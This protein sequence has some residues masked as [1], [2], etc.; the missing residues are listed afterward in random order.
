MSDASQQPD[1]T[2][3]IAAYNAEDTLARSIDSALAQTSVAVEVVVV[4]DCSTDS[5]SAIATGF[6]DG[7]VK[8]IRQAENG[9][10]GR[11]RNTGI[12]AASGAWIAVL[13]A[14]DEVRPQRSSAMIERARSMGA[15][16]VVDNLEVIPMGGG[17][18]TQMFTTEELA[19]RTEITL[20]EYIDS[21]VIFRDTFNFG[22]MKPMFRRDFL[23]RHDL[24]FGEELRIGEDYIMMA[25]ALAS[26]GRCAVEPSAG[27]IYHLR[28]E[29]ISRVLELRHVDAM[30]A[31]DCDFQARFPLKGSVLAAQYRRTRSLIEAHTFLTVVDAIKARSPGG[32]IRAAIAHPAALR[33]LR[34]P[35]AVRVQ[36]LLDRSSDV[37]G[38]SG[39]RKRRVRQ[40]G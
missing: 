24:V 22:Y 7:R 23:L 5:T 40:P 25:S 29:S 9:G 21:N 33:H 16:I 37:L 20:A 28:Q 12:A 36:R 27:Y 19:R 6:D 8:V 30:L 35:I 2:F 15:D 17:N 18:A 31:G 34:M 13:D 39:G 1:V 10:P 26:G 4:D 38:R 14:D 11:A 32:V 3:V